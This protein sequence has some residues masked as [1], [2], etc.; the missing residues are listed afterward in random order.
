M[1]KDIMKIIS[2]TFKNKIL[3][4]LMILVSL[5]AMLLHETVL[6]KIGAFLIVDDPLKTADLIHALGGGF[7][8]LDYA[9]RL[10]RQRFGRM[11]FLTG[12][13]DALAYRAYVIVKGVPSAQVF[14]MVSRAKNTWQEAVELKSFLKDRPDIQSVIVT[15][16]SYQM[17]RARRVFQQVVGDR[18]QLQF[19]A[20]PFSMS[21]YKKYWW[22]SADSRKIVINEYVKNIYYW[23]K[24]GL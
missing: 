5:A 1:I 16:T 18:V 21:R 23:Y 7:D 6:L 15:S 9:V 14:P 2:I 4:V 10:Y 19:S 22:K 20:L 3:I 24:Y 11:L 8:R 12:D 13:D 17:R